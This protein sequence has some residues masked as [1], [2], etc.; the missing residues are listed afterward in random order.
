MIYLEHT[1]AEHDDR[2]DR[3]IVRVSRADTFIILGAND[4]HSLLWE[5]RPTCVSELPDPTKAT[6]VLFE[7]RL[8]WGILRDSSRPFSCYHFAPTL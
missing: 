6:S 2:C 7:T 3:A 4:G 8:F 1:I 5:R